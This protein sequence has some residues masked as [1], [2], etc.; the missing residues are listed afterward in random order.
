MSL[1]DHPFALKEKLL[2]PPLRKWLGP[3][4]AEK[5]I[6]ALDPGFKHG[7]KAAVIDGSGGVVETTTIWMRDPDKTKKDIEALI[8]RST[9]H[10]VTV[11]NGH[12]GHE[13]GKLLKEVLKKR[14]ADNIHP[15]LS[16]LVT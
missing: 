9:P 4:G 1:S 10:F 7:T 11:G 15:V 8:D 16:G 12:G 14:A 13:V 2:I 6:L 5:N 3:F